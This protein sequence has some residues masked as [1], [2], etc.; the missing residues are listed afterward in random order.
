L[1]QD[2][3][4]A[5]GNQINAHGVVFVPFKGEF[6]FGAYAVCAAHQHGVLVFFADFY[7]CAKAA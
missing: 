6:E 3:V 5:H 7:Q 2:V 1:H 4:H